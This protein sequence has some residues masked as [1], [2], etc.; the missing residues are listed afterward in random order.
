MLH[1]DGMK[2]S[3]QPL[4][5]VLPAGPFQEEVSS[6]LMVDEVD[7]PAASDARLQHVAH[8][9]HHSQLSRAD[10]LLLAGYLPV[11]NDVSSYAGFAVFI[12]GI[13]EQQ[14]GLRWG[15]SGY[16]PGSAFFP[17]F[18]NWHRTKRKPPQAPPS[19]SMTWQA[20]GA[21]VA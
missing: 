19:S 11:L 18:P 4:H 7:H 1:V 14:D 21:H 6:S 5:G 3:H 2:C 15:M 10:Y 8:C 16:G 12:R 20:A 13:R 9:Q 17:A